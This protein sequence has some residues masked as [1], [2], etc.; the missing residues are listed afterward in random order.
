MKA[1]PRLITDKR[2]PSKIN[3]KMTLTI[4][5]TELKLVTSVKLLGLEIN[6][7]LSF[8]SHLK[9]LCKKL[10]QRIDVLKKIRSCLPMKQRLLYYNTMIRS[11]LRYV[12]SI[13]TSCDK[14][15]LG[16]AFFSYQKK[17]ARVIFDANNQAS[18]VTLFNSLQWLPSQ[19]VVKIAKCCVT[20]KRIKGVFSFY[21][22]DYL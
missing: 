16:L 3:E 7:E 21:I 12:S 14:E 17:A 4:K 5:G 2:L 9:K 6:S 8:T 10:S 11:V 15:S 18:S 13:W 22:E 20:N 1:K 19:E